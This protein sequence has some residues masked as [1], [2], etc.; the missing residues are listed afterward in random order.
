[1]PGLYLHIPFCQQK[2]LYCDF[3]SYPGQQARLEA[4]IEALL[5][6]AERFVKERDWG[7]FE[8][9][10][11]GGGTPSLLSGA[12]LTYLLDGIRQRFKLSPEAEIS[13]ECNPGTLDLEKLLAY[14]A[15]GVNRLSIGVQ[16]LENHLLKSIGR[17]HNAAQAEQALALAQQA[18]FKNINVDVMHGLPGQQQEEYIHTLNRIIDFSPTHISAYCLIVEQGTPLSAQIEAGIVK[19]PE[20]DNTYLM[21]DLGM[22]LLEERGY[23]RYEISNFA[24]PGYTCAH[25][26]NYWNNGAYLGL[27]AGAHSAW[28]LPGLGWS[29][30]ENTFDIEEYIAGSASGRVINEPQRIPKKEEQFETIMLGLRQIC[31]VKL[32]AFFKRFGVSVFDAYPKATQK[33]MDIGW[34]EATQGYIRLTTKGLDMQ[35]TALQYFLE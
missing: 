20:E 8:T 12:Q 5:M 11:L 33:L 30:W 23:K 26:I 34:L 32:D 2:C 4:Y 28:N 10:F 1:M 18:G 16:S 21:Q 19:L 24:R 3:V 35:N 13:M 22:L 9:V 27:G 7:L 25:N 6:E 29:R 14:R 17:I 31:G 15:A